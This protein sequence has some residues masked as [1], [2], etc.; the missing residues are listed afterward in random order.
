MEAKK[1]NIIKSRYIFAKSQLENIF[2]NNFRDGFKDT[3]IIF[4]L[5]L[6]FLGIYCMVLSILILFFFP[7]CMLLLPKIKE[8]N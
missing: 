6:I 1:V 3:K 8:K 5:N 2:L 7:L 4:P